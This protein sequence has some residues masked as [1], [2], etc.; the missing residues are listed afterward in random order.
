MV[1]AEDYAECAQLF[2]DDVRPYQILIGINMMQAS[3]D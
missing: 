1:S 2:R 3:I